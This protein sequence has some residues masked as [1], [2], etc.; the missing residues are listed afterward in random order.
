MKYMTKQL[1]RPSHTQHARPAQSPLWFAAR[2]SAF[3]ALCAFGMQPLVASAQVAPAAGAGPTLGTS[4]A[5]VPVVNI[6]APNAR[7]VSNN[8]FDQFNVGTNGLIVNNSVNGAQ[9]QIGGAVQGNAQL[10]GRGAAT[11][12]MQVTSGAPSQL[13]GKTEIAGQGANFVLANPAG[14]SCSGC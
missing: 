13:L 8:R 12:L 4:S 5:G 11:V 1:N 10:G 6:V 14:I 7:G 2:A 3:A 9:T